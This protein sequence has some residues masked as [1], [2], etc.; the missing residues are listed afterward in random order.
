MKAPVKWLPPDQRASKARQLS[1]RGSA[2]LRR[3]QAAQAVSLLARAYNLFPEDVPTAVNLGGALV[4]LG[5]YDKAIPILER[6]RDRAPDNVM[7]WINLGA[8]YL[9]D[10]ATASDEQQLQAIAAFEHALEIEPTARGVHYN[11]GLIHRHR[12][13]AEQARRRFHQAVQVDP[14]DQHARGAWERLR[15]EG[16]EKEQDAQRSAD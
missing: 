12:G 10:L 9:G 13:E 6:A 15:D 8:A 11:L 1:G 16:Q 7:I 4:M 14:M 5:R 2:L 3:G